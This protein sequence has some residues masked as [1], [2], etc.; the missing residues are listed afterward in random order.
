MQNSCV[1]LQWKYSMCSRRKGVRALHDI[2]GSHNLPKRPVYMH[3]SLC[4]YVFHRELALIQCILRVILTAKQTCSTLLQTIVSQ[5]SVRLNIDLRKA[6]ET[7]SAR[8][9]LHQH[10]RVYFE[11][12]WCIHAFCGTLC[13][14][15]GIWRELDSHQHACLLRSI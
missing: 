14:I 2:H 8:L 13:A 5:L 7:I 9:S 11:K 6:I 1:Q 10:L 15:G 4:S 3:C 12:E